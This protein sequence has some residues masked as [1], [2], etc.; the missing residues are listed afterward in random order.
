M[1]SKQE[2]S[3]LWTPLIIGL[4][5]GATVAAVTG[6]WWWSTVGVLVGAGVGYMGYAKTTR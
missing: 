6:H 4:I 3:W 5:I 1:N 2:A